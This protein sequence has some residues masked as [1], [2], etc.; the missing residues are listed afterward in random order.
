MKIAI[1]GSRGI[2][3]KYGGFETFADEISKRLVAKGYEVYVSCEGGTVPKIPE[4][5]NVYLF[6]FP[7]KPFCRVIYETIYDVY[8]LIKSSFICDYIYML[9]HGAGFFFFIPKIFKKKLFVNVDGIEWR[10]DKYNRIE[11]LILYFSETF[12][13]YLSD[14]IIADSTEINKY[15]ERKYKKKS[16]YISYGVDIPPIEPWD[17]SRLSAVYPEGT[18]KDLKED[19]Y[20][21]IVARL[22]PEN[23]IHMII[24]GFLLSGT[25]RKLVVTGNFLSKK[26]ESFVKNIIDRHKGHDR[27]I[28]TGGIYKKDLLNMLR[29]NCFAYFHG[30][31]A[32]GTNPSLLEAMI[33]KNIIIAHNNKYNREVCLDNVFYYNSPEEILDII[34]SIEKDS[35]KYENLKEGVFERVTSFYSWNSIAEK[36][37]DLFLKEHCEFLKEQDKFSK[38]KD[39]LFQEKIGAENQ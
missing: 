39:E 6:Y 18:F 27:I 15:I 11:K 33:M 21:L 4:Y 10:R 19:N 35:A 26:Y 24:E 25:D 9:G 14:V 17:P 30:H 13:V 32:G 38:K 12:A 31:S 2:P 34:A 3:A 16:N 28:F 8:S 36:Y 37:D 23:N 29:Q 22:E 5:N 7:L 20:Y 1:I